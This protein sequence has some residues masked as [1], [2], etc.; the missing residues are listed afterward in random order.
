MLNAEHGV[1]AR[2]KRG[3]IPNR[4]DSAAVKQ[5]NFRQKNRYFSSVSS[6]PVL[7]A[8]YVLFEEVQQQSRVRLQF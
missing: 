5:D 2:I 1:A 7:E 4:A 8:W 6:G 3:K